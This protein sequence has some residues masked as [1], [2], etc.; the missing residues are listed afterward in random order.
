MNL[1][2]KSLVIAISLTFVAL[3]TASAQKLD[4]MPPMQVGDKWTFRYHNIGDRREPYIFT[5]EVRRVEGNNVWLY[6]ETLDPN[7]N[8]PK[9][10]WRYD[11]KRAGLMESFV[12][13]ENAPESRGKRVANNQKNDDPFQ[14]PLEVGK[15]WA[16][17][18]F[19][20]DGYIDLK[21]EVETIEKIKTEAGEFEAYRIKYS[22]WWV[23]TSNGSGTGRSE[24]TVW[25]APAV[26][27][28]VRREVRSYLADGRSWNQ[29]KTE[30]IKWEPVA[31][32]TSAAR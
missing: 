18:E 24:R 28:E 12:Y 25:V 9:Y 4:A 32:A 16:V 1:T 22:G 14:F 3:T 26:K 8:I 7:T 29:T 23:F 30:L 27:R 5:S 13:D 31:T 17:R 15:K 2:F 21:A 10:W 19:W 11:I 20:D 6:G